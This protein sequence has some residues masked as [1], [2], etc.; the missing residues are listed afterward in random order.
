M[1]ALQG[2]F[3][4]QEHV[5]FCWRYTSSTGGPNI[6]YLSPSPISAGAVDLYCLAV[7]TCLKIRAD[8]DLMEK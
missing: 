1:K 5:L 6:P 2:S 7:V 8:G 4:I 3:Q